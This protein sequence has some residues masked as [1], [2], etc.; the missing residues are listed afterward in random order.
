MASLACLCHDRAHHRVPQQLDLVALEPPL[1]ATMVQMFLS[2]G[3]GGSSLRTMHATLFLDASP[4]A[5]LLACGPPGIAPQ[6]IAERRP[7]RFTRSLPLFVLDDVVLDLSMCCS[8][9]PDAS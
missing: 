4:A 5:Q 2:Q 8:A 3:R 9:I 7:T 6:C 1:G